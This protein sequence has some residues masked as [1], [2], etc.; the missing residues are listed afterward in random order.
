MDAAA[1]LVAE[2]IGHGVRDLVLSPGS[3]SQ[4]LALAAVRAASQG[5]LRLH[6]RIDERVA[7]FTALGLA[8]ETGVPA[9]VLCTSG[10]AVANLLPATMEAFH[11]GVP[12]LL[13]TADRPPELRGVGANQATVQPGMF[14]A[15]VRERR[16]TPRCPVTVTATVTGWGS[17]RMPS[18]SRWARMP[19]TASPESPA[20]C[21]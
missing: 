7:G 19:R 12:L 11:S 18:R 5:Q 15:W 17:R 14:A 13:L 8:R 21:T 2:L 6:V 16:S 4:A 9:A 3:R 1:S 10:T 20:P